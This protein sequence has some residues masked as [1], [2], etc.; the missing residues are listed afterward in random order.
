MILQFGTNI[1]QSCCH[2]K[3]SKY[4][5]LTDINIFVPVA[6]DT[7]GA[8]D[9]QAIEFIEE[10]GKRITAAANELMETQYLFQRIHIAIQRVTAVAFLNTFSE[11]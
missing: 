5:R 7:E 2:V 3:T 6:I 9:I 11:D 1:G 4:Q 8:W 10:L